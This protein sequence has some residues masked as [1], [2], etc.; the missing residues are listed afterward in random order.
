MGKGLSKG[1]KEFVGYIEELGNLSG[2]NIQD[3]ADKFENVGKSAIEAAEKLKS[4]KITM[5]EFKAAT[6]SA[7]SS[8]S[9]FAN[10]LKTVA[11]NMA[12][13]IVVNAAIKVASAI[14]DELN[15]TVAEQ[16][17][18]I[19]ELTQ[20]YEGLK[21]E[22]ETLSQKQDLT[23]SENNRLQ[24][25]ERRLELDEKILDAE[26]KQL[27][28]ER[29]GTKFTDVFD[30]DN[31]STQISNEG[32]ETD[33]LLDRTRGKMEK[34][35]SI[36][37]KVSE[38]EKI[39]QEVSNGTVQQQE[40]AFEDLSKL[41][42]KEQD[43]I[44]SLEESEVE[45]ESK[46]AT[47]LEIRE[48]IQE[49]L[50][51]GNLVGE[52]AENA[53]RDLLVVNNTIGRLEDQ[54][55]DIQKAAGTFDYSTVSVI[56]G[57]LGKIKFDK[58]DEQLNEM[59]EKGTLS[60]ESVTEKF[61]TLIEYL[62]TAGVSARDLVEYIKQL[63]NPDYVPDT[64]YMREQL[65]NSFI[66]SHTATMGLTAGSEWDNY[67]AGKSEEEIQVLYAIYND[68]TSTDGW[69]FE[70][71]DAEIAK[72]QGEEIVV[73]TSF[74]SNLTSAKDDIDNLQS[75][76]SNLQSA[77]TTVMSG[78][79]SSSELLDAIQTIN[80]EISGFNWEG[81]DS[82]DDLET[83]IEYGIKD[84][85]DDL[86]ESLNVSGTPFEGVLRNIIEESLKEETQL[87]AFNTQVDSLQSSYD[88]LSDIVSQYNSTGYITL[89]QLQT[90]LSMEPEYLA[91]LIDE[92]GQLAINQNTM[93]ALAQARL[94]DAEAQAVAS[95]MS[96]LNE[97]AAEG[98]ATSVSNLGAATASQIANL[99]TF[100]SALATT[101]QNTLYAAQVQDLYN[102]A[103]GAKDNGASLAQINTV[104]GNLDTKLK[105]INSVRENI[106]SNFTNIV[107]SSAS[108]ASSAAEDTAE[109]ITESIDDT[110]DYLEAQ[111]DAGQIDFETYC[112]KTKT[113]LDDAWNSGKIS[114]S[115]YFSYVKR[116]LEYQL[117]VK[118]RSLAA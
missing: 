31:I 97:L 26:T 103:L 19:E 59:A 105:M 77:L 42:Q 81:I 24:Y 111:L 113:L 82:L 100:N 33:L 28:N 25:L 93:E 57:A 92:N 7:S 8:A 75:S 50:D 96:E 109:D 38:A 22:Y 3:I 108:A 46:L 63:N 14:W 89:D 35:E 37:A 2:K 18:K 71:F 78:N 53:N 80:D 83:A 67:I 106:S 16:Q 68:G 54:I 41:R 98:Y 55:E 17:Q 70:D 43:Q 86:I 9:A 116:N 51:S 104:L 66:D 90:L 88:S 115:D 23:E 76:V 74:S 84:Q 101:A 60:V 58:I 6:S 29:Y 12:I 65:R 114:A 39:Y 21:S 102:A 11:A 45:L 85:V 5:E 94:D 15:V 47:Y 40:K 56:E 118:N 69:D 72:R 117:E 27:A 52:S 91:C 10:T 36:S 95:T 44:A 99:A 32:S 4:G 73:N 107:G 20:S 30:S 48:Q 110:M 34:L 1:T 87:E 13:M 49:D 62:Q 64:D 61:P 79:Y 112:E